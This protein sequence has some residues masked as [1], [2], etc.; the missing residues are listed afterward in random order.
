MFNLHTN[1]RPCKAYPGNPLNYRDD[2]DQVVFRENTEGSYGGVEFF[3]L[4]EEVYQALVNPFTIE[5]WSGEPAKMSE[6]VGEEFS[7]LDGNISGR[8]VSFIP[9]REIRQVWFFG[10]VES[11]VTIRLFGEK[12]NTQVWIE[13]TGIPDD[14]YENM[15]EGWGE[16]YL[17]P[18]KGFFEL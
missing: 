10:D 13:H 11:E 1:L 4:P 16:A 2:I 9:N 6:I 3:P 18:L 15:L 7:L 8:N 5:L 17:D 14:A 12:N